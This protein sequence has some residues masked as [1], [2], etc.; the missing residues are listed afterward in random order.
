MPASG[1][2][3]DALAGADVDDNPDIS[4]VV[5]LHDLLR[6]VRRA[7]CHGRGEERS[8]FGVAGEVVEERLSVHRLERRRAAQDGVAELLGCPVGHLRSEQGQFAHRTGD[9]YPQ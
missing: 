9:P 4:E 7:L 2:Q 5:H 3:E 1:P 6:L 8:L